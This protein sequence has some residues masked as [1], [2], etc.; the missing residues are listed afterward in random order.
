MRAAEII[1]TLHFYPN[2][3]PRRRLFAL[4]YFTTLLMSWTVLGHTVLGF[5]QSWAQPLVGVTVALFMQVLLECLDAWGKNRPLRF[6]SSLEAFLSFLPPAIIPG[7]ACAMLIYPNERL[8]PIAFACALSISSKVLFRA[9]IGNGRT[10]HIFN[11]SNI[12]IVGTLLLFP[13]VGLAPAYHFTENIT[14]AWDWA[15]PGLVLLS[16]I[17]IHFLFTGRLP[18]CVAWMGGFVLQA[19]L[20][21]LI[22]GTSWIAPLAPMTSVAFIIFTLYMIP[23]PATTPIRPRG[24]VAFGLSV[25]TLYGILQALHVVYGL[26]VA[27]A[28]VS[29]VR[30]IGSPIFSLLKARQAGSHQPAPSR[31]LTASGD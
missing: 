7:L 3:D 15:L 29:A 13:W 21:S 19:L 10:Q 17:A 18:L 25:A 28:I 23:D 30:G 20:R 8:L 26:F 11:P 6:A 9:P 14:G 12:G 1:T 16:G 5:E 22:F 4:W 27:L 31:S 24:Q 2:R